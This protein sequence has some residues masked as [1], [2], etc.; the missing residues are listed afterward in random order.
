[1]YLIAPFPRRSS[2]FKGLFKRCIKSEL[3]A[4]KGLA[5][6]RILPHHQIITVLEL[7]SSG[8]AVAYADHR[9]I[10]TRIDARLVGTGGGR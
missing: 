10:G 5:L 3:R 4:L 8:R 2:F 7:V 9:R 6:R 1:M